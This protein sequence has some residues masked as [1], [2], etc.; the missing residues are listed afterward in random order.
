MNN[1][2]VNKEHY[3]Q[4]S[5]WN[6]SQEGHFIEVTE[7]AKRIDHQEEKANHTVSVTS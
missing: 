4:K 5:G 3:N 1:N 6:A 7:E 2:K